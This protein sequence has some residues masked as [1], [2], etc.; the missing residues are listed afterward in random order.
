MNCPCHCCSDLWYYILYN[1]TSD[2][3]TVNEARKWLFT[4]KS[5][6]LENIPPTQAALKQNIKRASYQAYCWSMAVIQIPELPSPAEWGW[7]KD[8]TGWHPLWTMLS[9]A[10]QCCH[11]LIRYACKKRCTARCKCVRAALKCTLLC[12]YSAPTLEGVNNRHNSF[13]N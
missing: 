1:R 5:R 6:N 3:T 4:Q 2:L 9:E 11:E 12:S 10:S 7:Y 13:D 8:T